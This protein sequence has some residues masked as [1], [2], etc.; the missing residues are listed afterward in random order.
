MVMRGDT[1][2]YDAAAFELANGSMLDALVAQLP[3]AELKNGQIKVNGK[4]IESLMI[5][6]EDFFAGT[7]KV[8]LENLPAYTVK[9]IK[10]YDRAANDAYLRRRATNGKKLPNEDEHMVMDVQL[11]KAYSTG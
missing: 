8:A 3:G 1:L 11:K 6:G 10:V 9:N 4:H 5:N 7:P 2:V